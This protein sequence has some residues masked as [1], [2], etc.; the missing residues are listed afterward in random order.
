MTGIEIPNIALPP[1]AVSSDN[2]DI[3]A[4]PV[5]RIVFGRYR[6][7]DGA[8]FDVCV[9]ATQDI[10][11]QIDLVVDPPQILLDNG[12][13]DAPQIRAFAAVLLDTADELDQLIAWAQAAQ[14]ADRTATAADP[15]SPHLARCDDT[16]QRTA[17]SAARATGDHDGCIN[18]VVQ[19]VCR[20][21]A[22][23]D[24]A[25]GLEAADA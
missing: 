18:D 7:F 21:D 23:A 16:R 4:D 2:W 14:S 6:D 25:A 24:T 5:T 10:D 19:T 12:A 11:G 22:A 9:A 8:N 3:Y 13:F 1:L 15:G 20:T 17:S